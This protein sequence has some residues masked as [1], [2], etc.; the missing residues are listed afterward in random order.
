MAK[1]YY[2]ANFEDP[3]VYHHSQQC[4]D[5]QQIEPRGRVDTDYVPSD[6]RPCDEC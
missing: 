2:T 3:P 6:R 4:E 5:G 1:Y